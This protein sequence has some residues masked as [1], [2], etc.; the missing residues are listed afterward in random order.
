MLKILILFILML[1]IA[2]AKDR[3]TDTDKKRFLDDVKQA[4]AEHKVENKG[5]VDLQ[6]IKPGLY[7]ELEEFLKQEKFTRDEMIKIKQNYEKFSSNSSITP[8]KAEAA[9]YTFINNELDAISKKPVEKTKE[10]NVCNNWSCEDGL[11]CAPDPLQANAK[12]KKA[13]DAC[14]EALEC[15]SQECTFEKVGSKKKVCEDVMR[16]FRPLKVGESCMA[17][18]V[19]GAGS[20]L[21]F[22]LMTSG[23][24]ECNSFAISCKKNSDCCS[25]SCNGSVCVNNFICKDCVNKGSKP[26]RGQKC[27][28]G[29][30]QNDKSV[31]SPDA[32]PSV[33]EEVRVSPLKSFL[34]SFANLFISSAEAGEIKNIQASFNAMVDAH[35]DAPVGSTFT[36]GNGTLKILTTGNLQYTSPN[37]RS[38]ELTEKTNIIKVANASPEARKNVIETYGVDPINYNKDQQ[39]SN[40]RMIDNFTALE[41]A[42]TF[43]G[44]TSTT[45]D[46][47]GY[48]TVKYTYA[49]TEGFGENVVTVPAS[50]TSAYGTS[51]S[52]ASDFL[53]SNEYAAMVGKKMT[54]EDYKFLEDEKIAAT[55]TAQ[56]AST[57]GSAAAA[58]E[59]EQTFLNLG[60]ASDG[61]DVKSGVM[62]DQNKYKNYVATSKEGAGLD[63]DQVKPTLMFN[64]KSNFTT[65]D[66]SFKDD[67]YNSMK[68]NGTF[69]LEVA[70]LGFDFVSTGD[71]DSDYWKGGSVSQFPAMNAPGTEAVVAKLSAEAARISQGDPSIYNRLKAIGLAHRGIR[72]ATNVQIA[73]IN[74]KLTCACLDVQGYN[75]ITNNEKKKF[76]ETECD[77]YAKYKDPNTSADELTGD[78]SG[79]KGKRLLVIWTQNLASFHASLA[80]DNNSAYTQLLNVSKY[81]ANEAKWN[82]AEARNYDLFKFNIK[83]PSGSV[84]ALGAIVGALLAAGVIA[85]LGGFATT[86]ILSAWA[87][88]G[89]IAASAATGAGGL[90][91]IATLK[92]AWITMRPV[93]SD[94]EVAPRTYS[95]GKKESCTEYTRTLVQPYNQICN[96]HTSANA[97]IKSFVIINDTY[98]KGAGYIV[99]P[100][101]PY[102][103]SRTAILRNQPN[104]VEKLEAGFQ[105]AKNA[106]VVKNPGATGGGGKKGGGEFVSETYLSEVFI[107]ANVVGQYTPAIG[108]NM[109]ETYFLG[110][111]KIKI[112]KEAAK[113]FA[114]SEGFLLA[115]DTENLKKF[116]DYA[117]E[118]HF[119]WPKKSR[120]DEVSYPT[121]GLGTYLDYMSVKVSGNLSVGLAKAAVKLSKLQEQYQRDYNNMLALYDRSLNQVDGIK[122]QLITSEVEKSKQALA[123]LV[124]FNSLLDS[125]DLDSRLKALSTGANGSSSLSGASAGIGGLTSDQNSFLKAVSNLRNTRKEQIKSLDTYKKAMVSSGDKERAAKMS[126]VSSKFSDSFSKGNSSFSGV[127]SPG[128]NAVGASLAK[129]A[130][131]GAGKHNNSNSYGNSNNSGSSGTGTLFGSGAGSG[132]NSSST[133]SGAD[134]ANGAGGSSGVSDADTSKLSDAID[135]RN[136]NSNKY[137]STEGQTL[138]EKVTNAYIRN[139]DKVLSKKKD[140]DV[141]EEK[142]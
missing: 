22:S 79:L 106:M 113:Q 91:M 29:L 124:S 3:F 93:I 17:N 46:I 2:F 141:I 99:D 128:A 20:C 84:A 70:M 90:W 23:I 127:N 6:I 35:S 104:Y 134:S 9:F 97:C 133:K 142:Q 43:A 68:A 80:I 122:K 14:N 63:A 81:V 48:G 18:P 55:K 136:K 5:R 67:F 83:N 98:N 58:L 52:P 115:D 25:N 19:C 28:E 47:P 11:K 10:G 126:A 118:Y 123:S 76:F 131:D 71:A 86:S 85:I 109:Q 116:A 96:A 42:N 36:W 40:A 102:G 8:D 78:A 27:C 132:S 50:I 39:A 125:G 51:Y 34:I 95:C 16:C 57:D 31:C 139:Y 103:V 45:A 92:G 13:G 38:V 41:R 120:P 101:I 108:Q 65:C 121:V 60:K 87:A 140:K 15:A 44:N 69:D 88:A 114:I 74:K 82:T 53:A 135:A 130:A 32:P 61:L 111:D 75:K 107:D 119:V 66:M 112:I 7:A 77:E 117:Y 138:F 37:G 59:D 110:Q 89:I 49:H 54:A 94:Y 105:A 21:P 62:S 64:K 1:N 24:G 73:N 137:Q 30:Y 4:I 26:S 56:S 72:A 33:I 129:D 12:G 100:W